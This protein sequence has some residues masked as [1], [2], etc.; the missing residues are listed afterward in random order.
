MKISNWIKNVVQSIWNGVA[1]L[2]Q[3]TNDDYP[4]TGVQPFTGEPPNDHEKYS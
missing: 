3:P 2:F 1:R 4:E